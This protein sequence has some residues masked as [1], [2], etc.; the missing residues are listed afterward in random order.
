MLAF[1][2]INENALDESNITANPEVYLPIT[3]STA[4]T[5]VGAVLDLSALALILGSENH[6]Y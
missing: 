3:V 4:I 6:N 5:A 1:T 2:A